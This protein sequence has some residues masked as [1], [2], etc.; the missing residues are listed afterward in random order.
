MKILVLGDFHGRLLEGIKGIIKKNKIDMIISVGDYCPFVYR[1]LWFKHCYGKEI[2][3]WQIIGKDK[4]RKLVE[5][6][7]ELG[8]RVLKEL[9]NLEVPVFTV[10]GNLD[11]IGY[12][13][14]LDL[15]QKNHWK[16]YEQDFFDKMIKKYKNIKRFDYDFIKFSD[17]ILIGAYGQTFP[18]KVRSRAF[19]KHKMI[20]G[21]LFNRFKKENKEGK[22][23]FVSHNVPF[24]TKLDKITSKDAP[25]KAKGEHY[26]SKLIRKIVDKYQPVLHIGGHIHEGKGTDKIGKTLCLNP[27]AVHEGEYSILE[28]DEAKGKIKVKFVG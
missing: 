16:W 23:I 21:R 14:V 24:N 27:G 15:K 13:D 8:E 11:Y 9:N 18:G 2:E 26:G 1:K 5:R 17:L 4:T 10:V 6:D 25:K 12:N 3:L 22:V 19:R 20:L 7:L 28:F